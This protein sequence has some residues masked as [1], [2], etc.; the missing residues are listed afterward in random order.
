M[1]SDRKRTRDTTIPVAS[2]KNQVVFPDPK[3]LRYDPSIPS[4][5]LF[6]VPLS[7][8]Q[9]LE[10]KTPSSQAAT[11][12]ENCAAV[13][14]QL[15]GIISSAKS[16]EL[17]AYRF[18][19]GQKD[20]FTRIQMMAHLHQ[21]SSHINRLLRLVAST[22]PD[23]MYNTFLSEN[24]T[25]GFAGIRNSL[26]DGFATIVLITRRV[27][28]KIESGH[29]IVI[30]KT[31]M[32]L[33]VIDPQFRTMYTDKESIDAY[34]TGMQLNGMVETIQSSRPRTAD[35]FRR[36]YDGFLKAIP[37]IGSRRERKHT[38]RRKPARK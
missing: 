7:P 3:R 21:W 8:C 33:T 11:N 24:I 30:A 13:S 17:S 16:E 10:F 38:R 6:Q 36:D 18:G 28:D 14:A 29:F 1:Y 35:E 27:G 37:A 31:G 20:R 9:V 26:F 5:H 22:T 34:L 19:Q 32:E 2:P 4:S 12:P 23:D 15:I 25:D